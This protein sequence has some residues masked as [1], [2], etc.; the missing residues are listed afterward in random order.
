[1]GN[2]GFPVYILSVEIPYGNRKNRQGTE[3]EGEEDNPGNPGPA[4]AKGTQSGAEE[5]GVKEEH[6]KGR[7][8]KEAE[9]HAFERGK[10]RSG[11]DDKSA[12]QAEFDSKKIVKHIPRN[13]HGGKAQDQAKTPEEKSPAEKTPVHG[14]DADSIGNIKIDVKKP[15]VDV[16]VKVKVGQ[17]AGRRQVFHREHKAGSQKEGGSA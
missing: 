9:S 5:I 15:A 1:M 17:Q 11:D 6:T 3:V 8:G 2:R 16:L 10:G 4:E 7:Y 12:V 14:G 13:H